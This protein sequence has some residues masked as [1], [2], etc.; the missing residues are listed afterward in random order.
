[1]SDKDDYYFLGAPYFNNIKCHHQPFIS[2]KR[3]VT[4]P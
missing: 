1:M 2:N 3:S 4:Q